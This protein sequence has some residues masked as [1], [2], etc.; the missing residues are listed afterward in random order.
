MSRSLNDEPDEDVL[1]DDKKLYS[2]KT[3]I[4]TTASFGITK[5]DI[6]DLV[7]LAGS[8]ILKA[9]DIAADKLGLGNKDNLQ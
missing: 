6:I 1:D 5:K 2:V 9:K 3:H 4:Q 8:W 7:N